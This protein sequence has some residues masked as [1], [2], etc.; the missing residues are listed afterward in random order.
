[1]GIL[2]SWTNGDSP[3]SLLAMGLT[4]G[5]F[6]GGIATHLKN[7]GARK[8]KRERDEAREQRDQA[9]ARKEKIEPQLKNLNLLREALDGE[10]DELWK[11]HSAEPPAAIHQRLAQGKPKIV[12]V[13]NLKGGVGK[14]TTVA[15]LATHFG[16]NGK[17]VLVIDLDYQG[18]LSRML[19]AAANKR[20][21]EH[22]PARA[23]DFLAGQ[24]S[25]DALRKQLINL[26]P[27]I[28]N[29]DLVT[30]NIKFDKFENRAMLR[31][32][33]GDEIDDIRYRLAAVL[34][35]KAFADFDLILID[36]PPRMST[37]AMN[38]LASSQVL[39]IPTVLD[40]LSAIAIR[41]FITRINTLRSMNTSLHFAGV[42]GTLRGQLGGA[43][44]TEGAKQTAQE[45][46]AKWIGTPYLF[47]SDIKYF[48]D[49]AREAGTNVGYLKHKD[50]REAYKQLASEVERELRL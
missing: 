31:W 9:T 38:A 15:N 34:T 6:I 47:E 22:D 48:T 33:I 30:C 25:P 14:T 46:L 12:T 27:I 32:L 2:E 18:S 11:L 41:T 49:L 8:L 26:D 50:V 36:A 39:L 23:I 29:V 5:F 40:E 42:I 43:D 1:M 37:G 3:L 20:V 16:A 28:K 17:R 21:K 4:A 35:D 19:I 10:E 7:P 24:S 44:V 13:M 45:A